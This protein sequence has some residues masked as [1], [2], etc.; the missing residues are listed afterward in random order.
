LIS[1]PEPTADVDLAV[2]G[3][4]HGAA[5]GDFQ[6]ALALFR[7]ELAPQVDDAHEAVDLALLGAAVHA[8]LRMDLAV[9][10]STCCM[11]CMGLFR[12]AEF[13]RHPV[14]LAD[15]FQLGAQPRMVA[16]ALASKRNSIEPNN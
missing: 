7:A 9:L 3:A 14:R 2:Q 15:G 5:V 4:V 12:L 10:H 8:I 6:K 11:G 13:E 1:V 16:A